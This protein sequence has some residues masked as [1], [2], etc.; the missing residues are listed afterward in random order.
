MSGPDISVVLPAYREA[1]NLRLL[2]PRLRAALATLPGRSEIVVVDTNQ[3]MDDTEAV[4]AAEG[5]VYVRRA[6]TNVYGDA[7]RTGIATAQGTYVVFMDADGSHPPEFLPE[8]VGAAGD[9]D[10]V[11]ASRYVAGG[12]SD[13]SMSLRLMSIALNKAFALALGLPV[14]DGSNS[15]RLYRGE[16]L[17]AVRPVSSNF[18]VVQ[19]LLYVLNKRH[20]RLRIREIP[21]HFRTRI[22]GE[23]K[24]EMVK[25]LMGY[26]ATVVRLR[27]RTRP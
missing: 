8:L 7:V 12:G 5:A 20:A 25:F 22:H 26:A 1:A 6:P 3:P 2:L 17:R 9:A 19:E 10:V 27:T 23:T 14:R 15:F 4:C 21:F 13:N 11:I 16:L 24:R 18:D